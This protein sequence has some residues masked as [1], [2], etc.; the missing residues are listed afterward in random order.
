MTEQVFYRKWR[1]Q[2]FS[3]VVGQEHVTTTLLNALAAERVAHAYLFCGPRGT[4]KTSTGRILAKAINCLQNGKGEPCNDCAMC[5]DVSQGRALDLI[6]IDAASNRGIDEIRS[7][8]EKVGFSPNVARRKVYIIDEVHMLTTPAFNAL[9]K[10]LEEPPPHTILVLATTESHKLPATIISRCQRFDL[11]RISRDDVVLRLSQICESEGVTATNGALGLVARSA[12][13]SLRDAEN[14]LEQLVVGVGD[15]IDEDGVRAALGMGGREQMQTLAQA[16]FDRDLGKGLAAIEEVVGQGVD[17]SQFHRELTSYLRGLMLLKAEA[18]TSVE[19]SE[20]EQAEAKPLLASVSLERIVQALRAFGAA[21]LKDAA[22]LALPLEL[23]L[24][25]IVTG[26]GAQEVAPAPA[27]AQPERPAAPERAAQADRPA[28]PMPAPPRQADRP[29]FPKAPPAPQRPAAPGEDAA[30][31]P[32]GVD[33]GDSAPDTAPVAAEAA[34]MAP[35]ASSE[36]PEAASPADLGSNEERFAVLQERWKDVVAAS[37]GK[38]QK[39]KLDVLLRSGSKPVAIE[40]DI[41]IVGFTHQKFVN[42][43]REELENP[44][45]RKSLE[46]ALAAVLGVRHKVQCVVRTQEPKS[47]GGHLVRAAVEQAGARLIEGGD[48]PQ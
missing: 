39:Y 3:E 31:V 7:L 9:L 44:S 26:S 28:P 29:R 10:T 41:A 23:A 16:A 5:T 25:D 46:E 14:I 42:M 34:P 2:A 18:A 32:P 20:E 1:P 12:G 17:L 43:M 24:V 30:S 21:D 45:S 35:A 22:A 27:A 37:K 19:L 33:R 40:G 38:G 4:G 8:R 15:S 11:R 47:K 13:G 6:E 48:A 36:D